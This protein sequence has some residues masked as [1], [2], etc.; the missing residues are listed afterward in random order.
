M[1]TTDKTENEKRN[2]NSKYLNFR[3]AR[4]CLV[5]HMRSIRKKN[6]QNDQ[7]SKKTHDRIMSFFRILAG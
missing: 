6:P 2:D 7:V 5:V 3:T 1:Q 4:T